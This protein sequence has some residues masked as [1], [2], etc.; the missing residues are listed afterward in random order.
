[1]KNIILVLL[2]LLISCSC[3]A[4][5]QKGFGLGV[6]VG[7]N[8]ADFTSST[9][10]PRAGLYAGVFT[11]YYVSERFGFELGA[12]Y[13]QQG[14]NENSYIFPVDGSPYQ[15][16]N[17]DLDYISTQILLKYHFVLGFRAVLGAS[18]AFLMKATSKTINGEGIE[19]INN[20]D[21]INK[22]DCGVIA[23]IGYTFKFG[24]DLQVSYTRGFMSFFEDRGRYNSVYMLGVGWRFLGTGGKTHK[25]VK[26]K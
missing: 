18:P 2:G 24:L 22:F 9:G 20:I 16:I 11:D 17:Y 5:R 13:S 8:V 23:G 6:K 1:M 25:R 4:Q 14:S 3:F 10:G 12:Y 19:S 15:L 7:L 26:I 21:G